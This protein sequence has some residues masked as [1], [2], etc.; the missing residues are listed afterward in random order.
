MIITNQNYYIINEEW[1]EGWET[2]V[3]KIYGPLGYRILI[4][5]DY[6][7]WMK[8]SPQQKGY[9][10]GENNM[11]TFEI[12]NE[13]RD[14]L[15]SARDFEAYPVLDINPSEVVLESGHGL[16]GFVSERVKKGCI[17]PIAV[18]IFDYNRAKDMLVYTRKE[19]NLGR[20]Y[21]ERL[22]SLIER[23][24]IMLNSKKVKF[25]N[26]GLEDIPEDNPDLM[27]TI[28]VLVDINGVSRYKD[29]IFWDLA[30]QLVKPNG[31][32]ITN[33]NSQS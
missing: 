11:I 25:F 12:R 17:K 27:G 13:C 4:I 9:I 22:L 21:D 8:R 28:D 14:V 30:K 24:E 23:C 19:V 15:V 31:R 7:N 29:D 32:I 10:S 20:L 26:C 16:G 3:I 6:E 5:K 18:D 1:D 2:D 33:D